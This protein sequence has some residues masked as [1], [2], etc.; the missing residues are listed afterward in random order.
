[1]GVD[2][3]RI[4]PLGLSQRRNQDELQAKIREIY[5]VDVSD[6]EFGNIVQ[7][8]DRIAAKPSCGTAPQPW[9]H[10]VAKYE[11]CSPRG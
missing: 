7:I 5:G 3:K 1:M 6:I 11:H 10:P 2:F 9:A 4:E 8:L